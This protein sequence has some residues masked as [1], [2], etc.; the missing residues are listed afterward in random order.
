[1]L[2]YKLD[3]VSNYTNKQHEN[4]YLSLSPARQDKLKSYKDIR[5][6]ESVL[7]SYLLETRLAMICGYKASDITYRYSLNGKPYIN[8]D[9]SISI[10]HS[11]GVVAY[12]I[13]DKPIGI[14]IEVLRD[15]DADRL[16]R[17]RFFSLREKNWVHGNVVRFLY[18]WTFKEAVAKTIDVSLTKVLQ[19]VDCP[20]VMKEVKMPFPDNPEEVRSM[21]AIEYD[22]EYAG[23]TLRVSQSVEKGNLVCVC[24]LK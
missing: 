16:A 3:C 15:I 21:K 2:E 18:L 20:L 11:K 9:Y 12:G 8:G 22:L 17:S 13:C 5:L 19:E 10:S 14:D 23:K 24:T 6:R 4:M 7:A 1:M